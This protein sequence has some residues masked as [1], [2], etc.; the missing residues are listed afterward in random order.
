MVPQGEVERQNKELRRTQTTLEASLAHYFDLYEHAPVG[1]LT[2]SEQGLILEANLTAAKM[3]GV[4]RSELA[5]RSLSSF[6]LLE[7]QD[8]HHQHSTQLFT[9][10][11]P[12]EYEV[13]L[14][15]KDAASTWVRYVARTTRDAS[16]ATVCQA[17]LIAIAGC[18]KAHDELRPAT[19][20]LRYLAEALLRER[21]AD[22]ALLSV[23]AAGNLLHEL[24]VHQIE[25]EMQN[26]E[27]TWARGKLEAAQSRYFYLYELAPAGFFTLD[28]QGLIKEANLTAA[29]QL[30]MARNALLSQPL[31]HFILCEDRNIYYQHRKQLLATTTPQVCELRLVKRD[32][33]QFRARLE[34]TASHDIDGKPE[35]RALLSTIS[36][37][38]PAADSP[39]EC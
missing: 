28:E 21:A 9:T 38:K 32:G 37:L 3:L 6:I 33:T 4:A 12:Q 13:R 26:E 24:R 35:Y 14:L 25:L 20:T 36:E 10:G 2:I 7:D 23:D 5:T 11:E 30:G 16:G 39:Y 1:Y 22:Q 18:E 31:L 29:T 27:L 17:V 8:I 34:A 19:E 15:Q